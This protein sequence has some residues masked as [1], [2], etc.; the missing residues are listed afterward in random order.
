[1]LCRR[2]PFAANNYAMVLAQVLTE[3]PPRLRAFRPDIP[4]LLEAVVL[5]ALAKDPEQRFDSALEF[6]EALEPFEEWEATDE[7]PLPPRKSKLTKRNAP[8]VASPHE[9]ESTTAQGIGTLVIPDKAV[10]AR[11][12]ATIAAAVGLLGLAGFV[13]WSLMQGPPQVAQSPARP[14]AAVTAP[15]A[16]PAPAPVT[17]PAMREVVLKIKANPPEAVIYLNDEPLGN[18]VETLLPHGSAVKL[19]I[20]APGYV[21]L[22]ESLLMTADKEKEVSLRAEAVAPVAGNPPASRTAKKKSAEDNPLVPKV[23]R[24]KT[25]Y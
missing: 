6:A 22:A 23:V 18:P 9:E 11:P 12:W 14:P 4:E 3:P 19:R 13:M 17:T 25:E 21:P 2:V 20:A 15:V 7:S 5:R 24:P 10:V 8:P 16:V 1:M